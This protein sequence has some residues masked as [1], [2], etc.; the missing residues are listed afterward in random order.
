M[1]EGK[2]KRGA[3]PMEQCD[4]GLTFARVTAL[5]ITGAI[6]M[7]DVLKYE[8]AAVPASIFEILSS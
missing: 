7:N 2:K 3:D 5:M 6:N 4:S 1:K 8:Q